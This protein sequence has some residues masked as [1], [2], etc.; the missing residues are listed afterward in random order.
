MQAAYVINKCTAHDVAIP[1][2]QMLPFSLIILQPNRVE[3]WI[4]GSYHSESQYPKF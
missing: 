1:G 4:F 2:E 3:S